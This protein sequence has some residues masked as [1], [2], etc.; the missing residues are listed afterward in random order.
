ML[1]VIQRFIHW[2]TPV[3]S[4][5]G[6]RRVEGSRLEDRHQRGN[7]IELILT[8]DPAVMLIKLQ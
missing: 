8:I 2:L 4:E 1:F 7:S 6:F 3:P 5:K